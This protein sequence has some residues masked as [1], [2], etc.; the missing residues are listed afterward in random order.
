MPGEL[1]GE[2]AQPAAGLGV[3][4]LRVRRGLAGAVEVVAVDSVDLGRGDQAQGRGDPVLQ[5]G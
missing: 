3:L 4:G 5:R 1:R 2:L